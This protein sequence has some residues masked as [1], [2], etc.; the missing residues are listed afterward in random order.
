MV[1]VLSL[2]IDKNLDVDLDS[3]IDGE[4]MCY[5]KE[6]AKLEMMLFT[7]EWKEDFQ[8]YNQDT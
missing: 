6:R 1:Y 2:E 5:K 8:G 4:C 7:Y 3:K